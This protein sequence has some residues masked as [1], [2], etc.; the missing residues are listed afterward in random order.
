MA[1][2]QAMFRLAVAVAVG[3]SLE[4]V[5][6]ALCPV[7]CQGDAPYIITYSHLPL[8]VL[9]FFH[10]NDRTKFRW[11]IDVS[12]TIPPMSRQLYPL[13]LTA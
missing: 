6:P 5:S 8:P 1:S 2:E 3:T 7:L 4:L 10:A 11:S 9:E 12:L 13:R